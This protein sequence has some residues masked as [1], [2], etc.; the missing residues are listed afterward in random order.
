LLRLHFLCLFSGSKEERYIRG[1]ARLRRAI[2]AMGQWIKE[3][4]A[5]PNKAEWG[6]PSRPTGR[7]IDGVSPHLGPSATGAMW[8]SDDQK[9]LDLNS[10]VG[11]QTWEHKS[12]VPV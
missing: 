6:G 3:R 1:G 12:E 2:L 7:W 5:F 11:T 8:A 9:R 4:G 10:L